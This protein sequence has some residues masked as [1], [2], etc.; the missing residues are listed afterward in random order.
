MRTAGSVSS[1]LKPPQYLGTGDTDVTDWKFVEVRN[2]PPHSL[3]RGL[4]KTTPR[5]GDSLP[6]TR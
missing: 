5:P 3:G 1:K 6:D 4:E 2:V